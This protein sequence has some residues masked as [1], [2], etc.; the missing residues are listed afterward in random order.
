MTFAFPKNEIFNKNFI[1]IKQD[2]Y[3]ILEKYYDN[4]PQNLSDER[5]D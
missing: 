3:K 2:I 5:I 4:K 1:S